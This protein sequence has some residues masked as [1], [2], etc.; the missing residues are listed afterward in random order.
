MLDIN[1]IGMHDAFTDDNCNAFV[2]YI[3]HI[4]EMLIKN[5]KS[6]FNVP[7]RDKLHNKVSSAGGV[8]YPFKVM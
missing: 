6:P 4:G 3:L 8:L 7:K 5:D 1:H 2:T